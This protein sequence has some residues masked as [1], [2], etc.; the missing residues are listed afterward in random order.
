M[1]DERPSAHAL[2]PVVRGKL[3]PSLREA[4]APHS[5]KGSPWRNIPLA[6]IMVRAVKD[7]RARAVRHGEGVRLHVGSGLTS[8]RCVIRGGCARDDVRVRSWPLRHRPPVMCGLRRPLCH[9]VWRL[10]GR[11]AYL[12][13][14]MSRIRED[15]P[16]MEGSAS[17]TQPR[18]R[19]MM[20]VSAR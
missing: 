19:Q 18:W 5:W 1:K 3:L 9:C 17:L 12:S 20:R 11:G 16:G 2:G 4:F 15:A 6:L 8:E 10:V 7:G 13:S 14:P